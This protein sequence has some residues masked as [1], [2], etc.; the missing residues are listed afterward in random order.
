M[1]RATEGVY[2]FRIHGAVYHRMGPLDPAPSEKPGWAQLYLYDSRDER[3]NQRLD[4]YDGLDPAILG[5]VQD[6]LEQCN[7]YMQF[8]INNSQ[9]LRDDSNL[10]ISLR[11]VDPAEQGKDPRRYNRPTTDEIAAIIPMGGASTYIRQITLK[12][13]SD[14]GFQTIPHT[15]PMYIPLMYPLL[16]VH[17][18]DG[19]F[20]NIPMADNVARP[21]RRLDDADMDDGGNAGG[22]RIRV[23]RPAWHRFYLADRPGRFNPI[24]HAGRLLHQFVVDGWASCEEN[25]LSWCEQNQTT[26]RADL[27]CGLADAITSDGGLGNATQFGRRIILPSSYP[28]SPRQM[29]QEFQDSLALNRRFTSPDIFLTFTC[30]PKWK[31]ILAQLG[32]GETSNDRPDIVV[33]VFRI[34]LAALLDDLTKRHVMGKVVS[35][36][37]VTEFQKRGLPHAHIL[38]TLANEDKIRSARDADAIC[39]AEIPDKNADPEL[40]DI[41]SNNMIHGPCGEQY[42]PD[43]PC[44][45]DGKCSKRF[46]K[47]L[48]EET[49]I[50]EGKYPTYRRRN[51]GRVVLKYCKRLGTS[52]PLNN[53]WVVPY[54]PY[55]LKRY[56]AHINVE[57]CGSMKAVKYL[58]K[59]VYKGPDKA[60]TEV[61][62]NADTVNEIRQYQDCRYFSAHEACWRLFRFPMHGRY[63][64]VVRLQVHLPGQ[65]L[66]F[67]AA[68]GTVGNQIQRIEAARKTTLT[69]FF[70]LNALIKSKLDNG[71]QL[72]EWERRAYDSKYQDWPEF[73]TFDK[74]TKT[75][76]ER[77]NRTRSI[78]RMYA[79]SPRQGDRYYLRTLLATRPSW[80]SFEDVRTVHGVLCNT[81][82]DACSRRGLLDDDFEWDSALSEASHAASGSQQR[83]MF[84]FIMINCAPRDPVALWNKHWETLTDDTPSYFERKLGMDVWS[85]D[86]RKNLGVELLIKEYVSVSGSFDGFPLPKPTTNFLADRE[87]AVNRLL[88]EETH[89]DIQRIDDFLSGF[90]MM[91]TDQTAAFQ[92]IDE[93]LRCADN[94]HPTELCRCSTLFFLD[95]PGGTG[96]TF[97]QNILLAHVRKQGKVALAVAST[98]IAAT[99]LEGG[100]TA[101]SRFKI[102]LNMYNDST[103]NI[104]KRSDLAELIRHTKLILWDE[105][106]M[107]KRDVFEAVDRTFRDIL[108]RDDVPFGGV[109][110]CFSGDFRQTLPVIPGANRAEVVNSCLKNSRLW[111]HIRVLKL[112]E[113][114]RLRS[115]T[116]SDGDRERNRIFAQRLLS[117][118]ESTGD[119]NMIDWPSEY[120]VQNNTLQD[121]ADHVYDGL[122]TGAHPE[123]YFN[124]RAILAARNDVVSNLNTR[125]LQRMPG[126]TVQKL[127]ADSVVD[128]A[129]AS[130]YPIEVLNQLSESGLPPHKLTLKE[131]CPVMLLRNLDPGR[132]LCNGT[133]L[134]VKSI[135]DHVL[136]CTYLDR[137]RAGPAAP[138]DGIVLL[139][140][141]CCRSID[142]N[143]FVEFD[144]RQFPVRVCFAMTINKS[145]G[146]SLGR[147]GIYL[148]PEV[149]SHGQLYVALSRTTDPQK[150]WLADDGVGE[151]PDGRSLIDGRVKN[152]VYDEVFL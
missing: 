22:A 59:Y 94:L 86:Q 11:I 50:Q 149:F 19:W 34:K 20:P 81:F 17:G 151:D 130:K 70:A 44:M 62:I 13:R 89:Y 8:Y 25:A 54:N 78:G 45:R 41:V 46:P 120:V 32:P 101:H 139:P 79:V 134:Q 69:E 39:C 122:D 55:L 66:V 9:R 74:R 30:N 137:G 73:M 26:L 43:A 67:F 51:D 64:A 35:W 61:S 60:M 58:Y 14:G 97:L 88:Y 29:V 83:Q 63:P 5:D 92:A 28:G 72:A 104:S 3:L 96:K 128:P 24:L 68:D 108:D 15:S 143:S 48:C 4:R 98:G 102:P 42:N 116:L 125:L 144:R 93:A 133:R 107:V 23:T 2:T 27:Y 95:G 6:M 132:G 53:S 7:P 105:A 135:S 123:S 111:Q 152:I 82:K 84:V 40:Y 147:V 124:D 106:V 18:E 80:T 49:I 141:I 118:G 150:L 56:D 12:R 1:I 146:Q 90:N 37:Y 109:V 99:L 129:D 57:L 140:R 126:Q 16:F 138:A 114:M 52:V 33:K 142:D 115:S 85:D 10:T 87:P 75:W 38:L 121:L 31:E 65:Q 145:Q 21:N 112:T 76:R 148:N 119:N 131:G 47:P 71:Q 127:S 136:I 103:C 77:R 113:N 110:I 36:C 91:N 117:V 100:R